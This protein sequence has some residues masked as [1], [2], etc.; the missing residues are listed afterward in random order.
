ME[1]KETWFWGQELS[2]GALGNHVLSRGSQV[3]EL[4]LDTD[5][6]WADLL[7]SQSLVGLPGYLL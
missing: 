5:R 6:S 7:K 3:S 2:K 4:A 1:R